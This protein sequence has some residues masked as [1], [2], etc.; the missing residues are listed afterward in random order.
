MIPLPHR[1]P[2]SARSAALAAACADVTR[3]AERITRETAPGRLPERR[4]SEIGGLPEAAGLAARTSLAV[5]EVV[6]VQREGEPVA[7]VQPERSGSFYAPDA[8]EAGVD[9]DELVLVRVPDRATEL[10]RAAEL[11][12]RSGG[13]GLVVVDLE[14]LDARSGRMPAR[15]LSRLHALAREHDARVLLLTAPAEGALGPMVGVRVAPRR[16]RAGEGWLVRAE[17]VRDKA[18]VGALDPLALRPPEGA[19]AA[20]AV[21]ERSARPSVGAP[22]VAAVLPLRRRREEVSRVAS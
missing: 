6:R 12:L 8:A 17:L 5:A 19:S 10:A 15:A 18:G 2:D 21:H 9:L 11:L 16:E 13:F 4:L 7:W 22:G 1:S 20:D 3:G 14:D